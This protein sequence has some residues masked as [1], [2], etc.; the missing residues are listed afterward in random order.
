MKSNNPILITAPDRSGSEFIA[1]ILEVCGAE[2]GVLGKMYENMPLSSIINLIYTVQNDSDTKLEGFDMFADLVTNSLKKQQ[3]NGLKWLFKNSRLSYTWKHWNKLYPD[4]QWVIV[5]RKSSYIVN[6]CIKTAYQNT[7]NEKM[8]QTIGV[9]TEEE[10]WLWVIHQY[11]NQWIEMY[12]AGLNIIEVYPDRMGN[13][14]YSQIQA[15]VEKVGLEWKEETIKS[16]M[17][18]YYTS[19][20]D[21]IEK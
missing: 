3:I 16:M 5:R 2:T 11:E 1:H 4:A 13:D 6:S 17:Q 14:D 18:P 21:K 10:G 20:W 15:L 19:K 8:M 7:M 9:D 12:K